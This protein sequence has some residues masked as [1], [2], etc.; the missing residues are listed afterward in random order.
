[1][2][3][4]GFAWL[5]HPRWRLVLAGNR[6][7]FHA[8]PAAP[9]GWWPDAPGVFGGRDLE[10]GGSW[11]AIDRRGRLA[12]VTNFREPGAPPGPRS[13]GEL[14][15][16]FVNGSEDI[17]EWAHR[18]AADGA[19]WSGFN[20]LLFDLGADDGHATRAA[21]APRAPRAPR[22][23][24]L[25]NREP[26]SPAEIAPGV[27]G[28]SNHLLDTDWPKVRR[29]RER[30]SGALGASGST[31]AVT[32]GANAAGSATGDQAAEQRLFEALADDSLPA[33][34]ELPDTGIGLERERLLSPAMIRAHGY[35]TRASTLVLVGHDGRV[36]FVERSWPPAGDAPVRESR[37]SFRLGAHG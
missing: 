36:E 30:V 8:R 25:S 23:R 24:Y 1:M 9:A 18:T 3:L 16:G 5:S 4:I 33:D 37:A 2:C 13:R 31:E 26:A 20:L 35:G 32:G 10:A 22:A 11:L 17:D 34:P 27:H 14:V 21:R 28:L 19:Q 7:E 12:V 6:D 15:A 29:L